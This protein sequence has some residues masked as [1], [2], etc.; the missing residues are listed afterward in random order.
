MG[1]I[2]SRHLGFTVTNWIDILQTQPVWLSLA[3]RII[4]CTITFW[5]Q[6]TRSPRS[7]RVAGGAFGKGRVGRLILSSNTNYRNTHIE[8]VRLLNPISWPLSL[9]GAKSSNN[10]NRK[11]LLY[12]GK[13]SVQDGDIKASIKI[14]DG[15][16][17]LLCLKGDF[18]VVGEASS[19]A[20]PE[21]VGQ[22]EGSPKSW[23]F[24]NLC[25]HD[26]SALVLLAHGHPSPQGP[27]KKTIAMLWMHLA[28]Q[29]DSILWCSQVL[30]GICHRVW[31]LWAP[32]LPWKC[33]KT[34]MRR[35]GHGGLSARNLL[36]QATEWRRNWSL[37]PENA[38]T[39]RLGPR[40]FF[41]FTH[42]ENSSHL[43]PNLYNDLT[44]TLIPRRDQWPES[45]QL[46]F[47]VKSQLCHQKSQGSWR[48]NFASFCSPNETN[49]LIYISKEPPWFTAS[50]QPF[51][52]VCPCAHVVRHNKLVD[53]IYIYIFPLTTSKLIAIT[54]SPG[55]A[56]ATFAV[57]LDL[58]PARMPT[59]T[60]FW[61]ML[62][63]C[64]LPL[65]DTK[66]QPSAPH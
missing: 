31:K 20:R 36:C 38:K 45:P 3:Y 34:P 54:K 52:H 41:C 7:F 6:A 63:W 11:G 44:Q 15:G 27:G 21:H 22:V 51:N 60:T 17:C 32:G 66:T 4:H 56:L 58:A 23:V 30:P 14:G 61:N 55:Q 28:R 26:V 5:R 35:K 65:K 42:P 46:W 59:T 43:Y 50:A 29:G 8:G 18:T 10:P 47:P 9:E 33:V 37:E 2:F 48:R 25:L 39:P 1:L 12:H 40:C 13:A 24:V 64:A 62:Q 57:W 49:L 53:L 16:P 19:K